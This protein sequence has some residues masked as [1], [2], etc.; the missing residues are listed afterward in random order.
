ML[1]DGVRSIHATEQNY[2]VPE[3]PLKEEM[4]SAR[5]INGHEQQFFEKDQPVFAQTDYDDIHASQQFMKQKTPMTREN[6]SDFNKSRAG[7]AES[8]IDR[9]SA[10]MTDENPRE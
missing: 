9:K 1:E 7:E 2:F 10:Y 8:F 6:A 4:N 3:R 5:S